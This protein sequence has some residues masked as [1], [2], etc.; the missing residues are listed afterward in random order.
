MKSHLTMCITS[1]CAALPTCCS[2]DAM[3]CRGSDLGRDYANY[4]RKKRGFHLAV[5]LRV[6]SIG[7]Q[8]S[9]DVD[10]FFHVETS[11]MAMPPSLYR[12]FLFLD[13]TQFRGGAFP[14]T[15]FIPFPSLEF[16]LLASLY[17]DGYFAWNLIIRIRSSIPVFGQS[18]FLTLRLASIQRLSEHVT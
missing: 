8:K 16:V 3:I 7:L 15:R 5:L 12:L 2:L 11:S 17:R 18:S 14:L 4:K 13:L 10:P 1:H 6:K 9:L